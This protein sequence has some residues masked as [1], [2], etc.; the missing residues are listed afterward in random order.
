MPSPPRIRPPRVDGGA[1]GQKRWT[2]KVKEVMARDVAVVHPD[3]TLQEAA[4]RMR[5]LDVDLLPVCDKDRL[6]GMITD[7]DITVRST[8]EGLDPWTAQVQEAMT[9]DLVCCFEDDD[10]AEAARQMKERQV[11]QLPVLDRAR[12]LSGIVSLGDLSPTPRRGPLL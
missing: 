11:R 10:V 3:S 6:V 1:S 2:M 7:R 4:D 9:A 8:A 5:Q 12:H